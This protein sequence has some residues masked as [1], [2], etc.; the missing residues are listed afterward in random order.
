M[1]FLKLGFFV[2]SVPIDPFA[3]TMVRES[4]QS[5]DD[6]MNNFNSQPVEKLGIHLSSEMEL[7]EALLESPKLNSPRFD[8]PKFDKDAS[9]LP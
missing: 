8:S 2:V 3:A 9:P 5:L 6:L 4:R 7:N 1:Q